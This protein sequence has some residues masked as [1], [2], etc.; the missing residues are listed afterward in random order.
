MRP[1][2]VHH[3]AHVLAAAALFHLVAHRERATHAA[4]LDGGHL[5]ILA[6]EGVARRDLSPNAKAWFI[7][8]GALMLFALIILVV[9]SDVAK[10]GWLNKVFN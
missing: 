1:V 8:A 3:E 6:A 4:P 10:A 2:D 5:A 9:Y 7:N